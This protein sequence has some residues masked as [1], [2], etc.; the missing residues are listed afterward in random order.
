MC[1]L[2]KIDCVIAKNVTKLTHFVHIL[3]EM[4]MSPYTSIYTQ[5]QIYIYI[6]YIYIYTCV[7]IY[8]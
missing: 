2:S 8:I 6:Y 5:T 4:G 3:H 1:T 7:Y